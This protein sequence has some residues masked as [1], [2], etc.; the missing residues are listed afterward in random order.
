MFAT[1]LLRQKGGV[2]CQRGGVLRRRGGFGLTWKLERHETPDPVRSSA[3]NSRFHSVRQ[4]A[5]RHDQHK[6]TENTAL[7][8]L[9]WLVLHAAPA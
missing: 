4:Q 5:N 7:V 6:L 1:G 2:L 8:V 9:V 3:V